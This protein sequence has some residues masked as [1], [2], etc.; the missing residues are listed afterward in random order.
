MHCY[1]AFWSGHLSS[2]TNSFA[3]R[4]A[5]AS[6]A[7]RGTCEAPCKGQDWSR[8]SGQ[9]KPSR[10]RFE[11]ARP[12]ESCPLRSPR[13]VNIGKAQDSAAWMTREL[14]STL[15]KRVASDRPSG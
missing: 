11:C 3:H 7:L 6:K 8:D 5:K 13:A 10:P 1:A 2:T 14:H 4:R 15:G 12:I 9:G